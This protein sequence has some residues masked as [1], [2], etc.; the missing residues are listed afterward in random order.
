MI[1]KKKGFFSQPDVFGLGEEADFETLNFLPALN[2]IRS[3]KLHST[4]ALFCQTPVMRS[5]F[6][7][8]V[9]VFS[10]SA[11]I[12]MSSGTSFN[13]FSRLKNLTLKIPP[14]LVFLKSVFVKSDK[15]KKR[16]SFATPQPSL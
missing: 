2:L 1:G 4:T 13:T 7:S 12:F 15:R 10:C 11:I 16:W 14:G 5:A 8:H 3:T 9:F 6:Y